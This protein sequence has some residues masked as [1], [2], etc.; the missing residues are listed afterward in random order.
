MSQL[1]GERLLPGCG[2]T[3]VMAT[4]C[5]HKE[6]ERNTGNPRRWVR[7]P[8]GHPRGIGRATWG[9]GEA[10]STSEAANTGG[11]KGPHFKVNV[12]RGKSL[13]DWR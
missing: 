5:V 3:G 2:P 4:A 10:H 12:R 6:I 11:G 13:G 1:T 7:G 9:I 8:T